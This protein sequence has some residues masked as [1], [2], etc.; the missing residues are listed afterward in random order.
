[1]NH[2]VCILHAWVGR[3]T[4]LVWRSRPSY[5]LLR[6]CEVSH[7]LTDTHVRF[8]LTKMNCTYLFVLLCFTRADTIG[9]RNAEAVSYLAWNTSNANES[10]LTRFVFGQHNNMYIYMNK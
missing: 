7:T 8:G 1:M 5:V 2:S 4:H 10:N 3:S 6:P 9:V